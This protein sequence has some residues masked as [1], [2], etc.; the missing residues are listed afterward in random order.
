MPTRRVKLA[1]SICSLAILCPTTVSS[2]QLDFSDIEVRMLTSGGKLESCSIG[3]EFVFKDYENFRGRMASVVGSLNW[4]IIGDRVR[5][6]MKT[7]GRVLDAKK[8]LQRAT[9]NRPFLFAVGKA[10]HPFSGPTAC[11]DA[12]PVWSCG[13]WL[14]TQEHA[15]ELLAS[16]D[17]L[18]LRFNR[19]EGDYDFEF[20]IALDRQK[21]MKLS[22]CIEKLVATAIEKSSK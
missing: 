16:L 14:F 2:Q 12:E 22:D 8:A 17:N 9:I 6:A 5:L 7:G 11:E 15:M 18:E 13:I 3:Y 10:Y 1:L 4:M 21:H 19:K 20:P